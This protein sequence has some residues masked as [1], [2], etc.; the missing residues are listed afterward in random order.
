MIIK[1][2]IVDFL[3]KNPNATRKEIEA[4]TGLSE[5]E[6]KYCVFS[7]AHDGIL[8]S[9]KTDK[10]VM[11]KNGK[12]GRWLVGFTVIMDKRVKAKIKVIKAKKWYKPKNNLTGF[13]VRMPLQLHNEILFFVNLFSSNDNLVSV[14]EFVNKAVVKYCKELKGNIKD[15]YEAGKL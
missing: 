8:K 13:Y 5:K 1:K 2:T 12:S 9:E 10:K 7:M 6:V 4:G 14:S 15:N 3:L 11:L